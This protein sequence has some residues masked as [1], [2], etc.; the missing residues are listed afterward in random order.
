VLPQQLFTVTVVAAAAQLLV[1][2]VVAEA[3][4]HSQV[5]VAVVAPPL[6]MVLSLAV[7]GVAVQDM[8]VLL[9]GNYGK[10]CS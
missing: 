6:R 3:M 2:M 4:V 7:A 9:A 1:H 10:P 8:F 5:V